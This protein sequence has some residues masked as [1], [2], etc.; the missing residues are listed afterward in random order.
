MIVNQLKDFYIYHFG[1]GNEEVE[2]L[3]DETLVQCLLSRKWDEA[4]DYCYQKN[5]SSI[6][7]LIYL[8]TEAKFL[9]DR[10]VE[11]E[12][13]VLDNCGKVCK[14]KWNGKWLDLD[15]IS[16]NIT[17][18]NRI[19]YKEKIDM[20]SFIVNCRGYSRH[21]FTNNKFYYY[22]LNDKYSDR[23]MDILREM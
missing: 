11:F 4:L 20:I 1:N 9:I 3:K 8:Y 17:D 7:K 16:I 23:I 19:K 15:I 14:P 12:K 10:I 2:Y 21:I 13:T 6:F 5:Y 22:F 18:E